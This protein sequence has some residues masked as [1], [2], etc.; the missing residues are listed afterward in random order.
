MKI[1]PVDNSDRPSQ[2]EKDSRRRQ[3]TGPEKKH[4][5]EAGD[6][7]EISGSGRMLSERMYYRM[8][9]DA[10][11]RIDRGNEESKSTQASEKTDMDVSTTAADK[12]EQLRA[13]EARRQKVEEAK[14]RRDSGYYD[15]P[16]S[17]CE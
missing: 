8:Q 10:Q 11:R 4:S 16:C 17:Y 15:R 1:G 7:V 5:G 13:E 2:A 6:S 14:A 3:E 12:Q 9:A